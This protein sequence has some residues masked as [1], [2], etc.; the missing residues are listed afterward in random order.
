MH[1]EFGK[2]GKQEGRN[3]VHFKWLGQACFEI[4]NSK[5]IVT[6]PHDGEGVGLEEPGVK[7]DVVTVSHDHFDH[8]AGV[9]IVKKKDTEVVKE[10][11]SRN[12]EGI[13][14]E[15]F[16]SYHDKA[17]GSKRGKNT[18][19]KFDL[20]GFKIVHLGDL[21]HLLSEEKVNEIKPVDILLIPVGGNYTIDG[22]E[23]LETVKQLDPEIT[24]PMHYKVPGLTVD[25]SSDDEFIQAAM[26]EG[27]VVSKEDTAEIDELPE[28]KKVIKIQCK[29]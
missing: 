11:G 6:D 3:M 26:Q 27:Y 20:E 17:E 16:D 29:R 25:I 4:R 2:Y 15:G 9:D 23:A 19:Y 21:G 7:G 14:V 22:E 18:I 1:I 24:I 13:N 5:I 28:K 8:S 12:I 10:P